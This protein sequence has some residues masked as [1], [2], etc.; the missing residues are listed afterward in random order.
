MDRSYTYLLINLL[1]VAMPLAF[2]FEPRVRFAGWWKYLFPAMLI[3]AAP[4]LAWDA[5]FTIEG[6]WGFNPDYLTGWHLGVLPVEEILFFLAIPY[7]SIFIYAA[8]NWWKPESPLM[9]RMAK[10]ITWFFILLALA[11]LVFFYDRWYT[12]VNC[13]FALVLLLV[14]QFLVKGSYMG[15]FW[16]FYLVHLI[17]FFLVNG[18]LTGSWIKALVVWYN[19]AENTGIRIGT[20]PIEDSMYSL[21]LMLMNIMLIERWKK[22]AVI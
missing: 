17:P 15:R 9:D 22:P 1:S 14:Q 11:G 12:A 4:F 2:S 19:N 3:T 16:R 7:A 20:V 8:W 21:S 6:V 18:I 10:P 5:F 13:A